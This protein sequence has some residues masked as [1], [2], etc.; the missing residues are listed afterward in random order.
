MT[1]WTAIE[2]AY[3]RLSD[4]L[5]QVVTA[6]VGLGEPRFSGFDGNTETEQMATAE[7]YIEKLDRFQNFEGRD[8]NAHMPCLDAYRRMLTS[9]EATVQATHGEPL[10][11]DQL[12][13]V[14]REQIHPE[15]R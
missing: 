11:A 14:L 12:V 2:F 9:F 10:S 5:K 8:L 15:N 3:G 7:F 4:D 1:M 13:A 6:Q